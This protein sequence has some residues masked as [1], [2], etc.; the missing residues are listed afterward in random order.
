MSERMK[1][2]T[3]KF[4]LAAVALQLIGFGLTAA[5]N[6]TH[7]GGAL[8]PG[9]VFVG[10]VPA[11]VTN[12]TNPKLIGNE[13]YIGTSLPGSV[14]VTVD[15]DVYSATISEYSTCTGYTP[16][17]C[18]LSWSVNVTNPL[19]D[20]KYNV[21]V[22]SEDI[23][24]SKTY[25]DAF[26]VDTIDPV[27]TV[28]SQVTNS[29]LPLLTGTVTDAN[30]KSLTVKVNGSTYSLNIS[31]ILDNKWELQTTTSIPDGVYDVYVT[32][33]DM[34]GNIGYDKSTDELTVTNKPILAEVTPVPL[35]SNNITPSYGFSSSEAGE[36]SFSGGCTSST[37]SA[38][39]GVNNI[40]FNSLA[41]GTYASCEIVVANEDGV[42]SLPLQVTPFTID[43]TPAVVK[44]TSKPVIINDVKTAV[45]VTFTGN[46]AIA[47][48]PLSEISFQQG[49]NIYNTTAATQP[50]P[51]T[52]VVEVP[53]NT[54]DSG[55][56]G[57]NVV[58]IFVD[59]VGNV[60]DFAGTLVLD[61]VAPLAV[62]NL[63]AVVNESGNAV[64]LTWV[65]P[66]EGTYAG[67]KIVRDGAFLT[68]V[69]AGTN[70]FTDT[71]VEKDQTYTYSVIAY[72]TAGNET[73]TTPVSVT[74][75][76]PRE[77]AS[78]VSDSNLDQTPVPST[79][80]EQTKDIEVK[81][82][83]KKVED[84]NFPSWGI[85]LLIIL[86]AIG[87]YLIYSQ[88]PGTQTP[89]TTPSPKGKG[90]APKKK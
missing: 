7:A 5:P 90:S 71:N 29:H 77:I 61:T 1:K 55:E 10:A 67:L 43:A 50:Q 37:T 56:V 80:G 22:D 81:K 33:T 84:N 11:T 52:L 74:V 14:N 51:N 87:G 49:I 79:L 82:V 42:S 65:N 72:D 25:T 12:Y 20:A 28:G 58:G 36:I 34:A 89:N 31:F 3:A 30:L 13:D 73:T 16:G 53:A 64:V 18:M 41:D 2:L 17:H 88:N 27:V 32:A 62:S 26:I 45:E 76:A 59:V 24:Y 6:T 19:T 75:P 38:L 21:G 68:T 57:V 23:N 15:G 54:F 78:G 47:I 44:M 40:V 70:T 85:L 69:A 60:T 46:K 48:Q 39:A 63:T 35:I 66:A 83:E 86:A 4:A 9:E 8:L